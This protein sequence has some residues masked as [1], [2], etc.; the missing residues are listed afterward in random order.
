MNFLAIQNKFATANCVNTC[1]HISQ[2][3]FTRTVFSY[4]GM[5]LAFV[6]IEG[7]ILHCLGDTKGFTQILNL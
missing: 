1:Q 6:D 4:E 2:G 5:N 3:R 7:N